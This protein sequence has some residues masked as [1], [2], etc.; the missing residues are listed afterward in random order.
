MS[1]WYSLSRFLLPRPWYP[2]FPFLLAVVALWGMGW[3]WGSLL[4]WCLPGCPGNHWAVMWNDIQRPEGSAQCTEINRSRPSLP[5][6]QL[7]PFPFCDPVSMRTSEPPSTTFLFS[8]ALPWLET[9]VLGTAPG[10]V[11][12]PLYHS[13]S[14]LIPLPFLSPPPTS[15]LHAHSLPP[16]LNTAA[17]WL[18]LYIAAF[19]G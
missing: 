3:A 14:C 11:M 18:T 13:S 19:S 5:I 8:G 17:V 4:V 1:W 15:S 2:A 9:E 16:P 6:S 12:P 7:D 10:P